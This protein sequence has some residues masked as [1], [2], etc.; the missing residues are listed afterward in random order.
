MNRASETSRP[1][2]FK[3]YR[4]LLCAAV[5]AAFALCLSPSAFAQTKYNPS[6]VACLSGGNYQT[7]DPA[8][9]ANP[10]V[11]TGEAQLDAESTNSTVYKVSCT[12]SG[13]PHV[14]LP[15]AATLHVAVNY[16]SSV[17]PG[18]NGNHCA[19]GSASVTGGGIGW[20]TSCNSGQL[21]ETAEVPADTWLDTIDVT[22]EVQTSSTNSPGV[23]DNTVLTISTM[24]IY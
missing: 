11:P 15:T 5:A 17:D 18:P 24:S 21:M 2:F 7:P 1:A 10:N 13:F 20:H 16:G 4:S 19:G 12:W 14:Q 8:E 9:P 3:Q 22:G 23:D 6:S